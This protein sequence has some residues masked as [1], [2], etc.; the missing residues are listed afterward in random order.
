MI[1]VLFE[2]ALLLI[3]AVPPLIVGAAGMIIGFLVGY[4]YRGDREW[5]A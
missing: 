1:A 2:S 5:W 3:G 4:A